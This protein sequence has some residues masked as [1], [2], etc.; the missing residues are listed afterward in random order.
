MLRSV[1]PL[2]CPVAYSYTGRSP[3]LLRV[4]SALVHTNLDGYQPLPMLKR[5][6]NS[7]TLPQYAKNSLSVRS[8][9]AVLVFGGKDW[10]DG[11]SAWRAHCV[12]PIRP[13][14]SWPMR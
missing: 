12:R 1:N 4:L 13:R 14:S 3:G 7:F 8:W 10:G 9:L 11:P 2:I 5:N 6:R